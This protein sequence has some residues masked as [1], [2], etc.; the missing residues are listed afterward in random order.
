M[1][2]QVSELCFTRNLKNTYTL[3][4]HKNLP[5]NIFKS[6]CVNMLFFTLTLMTSKHYITT[7][8]WGCCKV[9]SIEWN[10]FCINW[11]C[12]IIYVRSLVRKL[13]MHFSIFV[14]IFAI[15]D[16]LLTASY[17][18]YESILKVEAEAIFVVPAFGVL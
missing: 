8:I 9:W 16:L 17:L 3:K 11:L 1:F 10:V 12:L 13:T 18:P 5:I 2:D 7:Y 14:R 4:L 6:Q 15:S